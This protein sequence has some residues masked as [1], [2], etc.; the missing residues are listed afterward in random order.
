MTHAPQRLG[1]LL[2]ALASSVSTQIDHATTVAAGQGGGAPAAL[3]QLAQHRDLSVDDLR[4]RLNLTHSAVVRL[5]DRLAD[6]G[7]ISRDRSD[8]DGR[9]RRLSL[10]PAGEALA[11]VV[12]DARARVLAAA[13]GPLDARERGLLEGILDRLL[14]ALPTSADHSSQVCRLCCLRDCPAD[15]C[16]VEDRYQEYV[17]L[18]S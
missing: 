6:R 10:T 14:L 5:L 17:R 16:P 8:E 9:R 7:L 2:G 4:R 18:E 13:L 11:G 3:V 1:N 15:R 12:L